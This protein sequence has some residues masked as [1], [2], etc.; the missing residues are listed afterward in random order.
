[1]DMG[2]KEEGQREEGRY[3]FARAH[4][5]ALVRM[6]RRVHG[7]VWYLTLRPQ[8]RV[9]MRTCVCGCGDD[10]SQVSVRVRAHVCAALVLIPLT[11]T[12]TT[13]THT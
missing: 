4:A 8:E 12:T 11:A 7:R 6:C 9:F 2:G 10:E 1:M 5:C 3:V 13:H